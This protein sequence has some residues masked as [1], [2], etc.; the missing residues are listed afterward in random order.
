M[1]LPDTLSPPPFQE[2]TSQV[3]DYGDS[4]HLEQPNRFPRRLSLSPTADEALD[5]LGSGFSAPSDARALEVCDTKS[6][7]GESISL[8]SNA[9]S[10][11]TLSELIREKSQEAVSA[12][13]RTFYAISDLEAV[14]TRITAR[15]ELGDVH[16]VDEILDQIFNPRTISNH[17]TRVFR[18]FVILTLMGKPAAIKDFIDDEIYDLDLPFE[19]T[20]AEGILKNRDQYLR[21][22]QI[23][24]RSHSEVGIFKRWTAVDIESFMEKQHAVC[25]P[26][27][28]LNTQGGAPVSHYNLHGQTILPF[29]ENDQ[30]SLRSEGRSDVWSVKIHPAH[31]ICGALGV[32]GSR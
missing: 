6:T 3:G 31:I 30:H 20:T 16:D 18:I 10:S 32:S 21:N 11:S 8:R 25:V 5:Q 14:V 1:A 22:R 19:R 2:G 7:G 17:K 13:K 9:D 28:D 24:G 27:F 12:E 29:I 15:Q 23:P 26:I 4:K